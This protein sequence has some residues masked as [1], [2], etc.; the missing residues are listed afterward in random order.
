MFRPS[1]SGIIRNVV[2]IVKFKPIA[3]MRPMRAIAKEL[4]KINFFL[5]KN[6]DLS[7]SYL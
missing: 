3:N 5:L 4:A 6:L 1:A 7:L 2:Y